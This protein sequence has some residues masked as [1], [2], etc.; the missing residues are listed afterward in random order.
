MA[1]V[2]CGGVSVGHHSFVGASSTIIQG[3]IIGD[4][5]VVGANSTIL[6]NVGDNHIVYGVVKEIQ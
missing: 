5:C 2:L 4:D 3:K 1:S 6:T